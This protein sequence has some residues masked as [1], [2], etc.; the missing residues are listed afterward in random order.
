MAQAGS[1]L[2]DKCPNFIDRKT[3]LDIV[4]IDV[5]LDFISLAVSQFEGIYGLGGTTHW[6]FSCFSHATECPRYNIHVAS[7]SEGRGSVD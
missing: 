3:A 7:D 5:Y 6:F 1:E 2:S 4:C